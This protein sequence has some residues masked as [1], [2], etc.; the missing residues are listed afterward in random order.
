MF[1]SEFTHP[2]EVGTKA[3]AHQTRKYSISPRIQIYPAGSIPLNSRAA[4]F[5]K[6]VGL[7]RR[8]DYGRIQRRWA[9]GPALWFKARRTTHRLNIRSGSR[10]S[11]EKLA[12]S[13]P[14]VRET[15]MGQ[16]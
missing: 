9:M 10:R 2:L 4:K 15:S 13:L 11:S 1:I 7:L 5:T 12:R 6:R 16:E 14:N 3:L 8:L